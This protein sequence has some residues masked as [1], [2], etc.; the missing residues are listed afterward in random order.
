MAHGGGGGR[1]DVLH[2]REGKVTGRGNVRENMSEGRNVLHANLL[3]AQSKAVQHVH[4][5]HAIRQSVGTLF[6]KADRRL[7]VS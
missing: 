7:H 5:T 3:S 6:A 2:Q 1:G 4:D